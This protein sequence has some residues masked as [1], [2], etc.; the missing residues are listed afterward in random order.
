MQHFPPV[1]V[2][3]IAPVAIAPHRRDK[4][5][6]YQPFGHRIAIILLEWVLLLGVMI[7]NSTLALAQT[8]T[9]DGE[10]A[11]QDLERQCAFGPRNPG[12]PGYIAC[13]K[14]LVNE[15]EK[16]AG[17]VFQQNFEAVEALTGDKRSL[18]NIIAR[19]PGSGG[20]PTMLCAHWDTRAYADQD[21]DPKNRTTPIPGANDGASGVAVLLEIARIAA[22]FPP[23]RE[24]WIVFFDGEDMGRGGH[25]EE[26]A[27]GSRF[28][29]THPTPGKPSDA[30]LL[31]MVGDADL[32]IPIEYFSQAKAPAL[33][34][35]LWEL[36]REVGS[37]AFVDSPGPA[38]ADDHVPLQQIGVRAVDLIDFDYT[39]WH[40]LQDTP[41]KCSAESLEQVGKVLVA[42]LYGIK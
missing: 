3:F 37:E 34:R 36:A 16:S 31:D 13:R 2:R 20:T 15:L 24:L 21:P 30:I 7:F 5:R 27:L 14:W 40:T 18:T 29:A 28:W 39:W 12:S 22:E 35:H 8:P 33:R 17:E 25:S 6:R 23:P 1:A 9:F 41:D 32:E 42:Y 38:V 10:R 19:F 26:Y 11:F 4:S